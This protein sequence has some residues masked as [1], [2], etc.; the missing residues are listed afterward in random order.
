VNVSWEL[1][2]E[3][4]DAGSSPSETL[5][6]AMATCVLV[7]TSRHPAARGVRLGAF[8][9]NLEGNMDLRGFA[10]LDDTL[11]RVSDRA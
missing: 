10:D 6:H 5:V 4:V 2:I 8:K 3:A 7:T 9:V 1:D 11:R